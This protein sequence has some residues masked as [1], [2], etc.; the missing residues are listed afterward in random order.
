MTISFSNSIHTFMKV[1]YLSIVFHTRQN[2]DAYLIAYVVAHA[3]AYA[4]A[5]VVAYAVV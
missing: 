1:W 5:Y 3:F 4:V 2:G